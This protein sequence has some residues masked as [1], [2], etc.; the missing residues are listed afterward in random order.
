MCIPSFIH[1]PCVYTHAYTPS[2]SASRALAETERL[3]NLE[4]VSPHKYTFTYISPPPPLIH[5]HC[6]FSPLRKIYDAPHPLI[7]HPHEH[8]YMH[9]VDVSVAPCLLVRSSSTNRT[10]LDYDKEM[11]SNTHSNFVTTLS[12]PLLE[13]CNNAAST[14]E[15]TSVNET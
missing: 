12:V 8:V 2:V 13:R 9:N 7:H 4:I 15:L 5:P 3:V 1:H 10:K 14:A 11:F 6:F